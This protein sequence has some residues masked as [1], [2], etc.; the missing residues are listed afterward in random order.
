MYRDSEQYRGSTD[1]FP[2]HFRRALT[3]LE[4]PRNDWEPLLR[5]YSEFN[6]AVSGVG[7]ADPED[8]FDLEY[9]GRYE[10]IR[11]VLGLD[12]HGFIQ[13]GNLRVFLNTANGKFYPALGRDNIPAMLDLSGSRTPELQLNTYRGGLEPRMRSRCSTSWPGATACGRRSI[14]RSTASS[15]RMVRGSSG[16]SSGGWW[17]AASLTP[18]ELAIV[19]PA[20]RA[21]S[22]TDA[23]PAWSG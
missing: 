19:R 18:A 10:T 22:D 8:F 4:V 11:Y 3:Q 16:K 6:A 1:D 9:L 7:A 5:R 12:G 20:A 17:R 21:G 14:G 15:S 23:A 13:G 2:V